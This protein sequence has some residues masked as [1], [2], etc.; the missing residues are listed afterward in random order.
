MNK[1]GGIRGHMKTQIK[2]N[3]DENNTAYAKQK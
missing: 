2:M 1:A 3:L